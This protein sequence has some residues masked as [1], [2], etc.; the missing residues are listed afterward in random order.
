[1]PENPHITV[2]VPTFNEAEAITEL[3]ERIFS[4]PLSNLDV[5]IVDDNSPDNTGVIADNLSKRYPIRVIHRSSKEGLGKA[6]IHVFTELLSMTR[7][8]RPE[9]IIQ[10][11][12]DLSHNPADIPRFLEKIES[13]DVVLGSRYVT[14]GDIEYWSLFRRLVSRLGNAYAALV[15]GLPYKDLTS[16]YKC[17]RREVLEAIR[18]NTLSSTG[19]NFQIET[20]Y[21]AHKRGF[22][23]CEIPLVFT[24]RKFG[25]SKFHIG[26]IAESFIKVLM[27]RF[28]K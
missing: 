26:I 12:A 18:L 14:G 7:D 6:Y 17:F 4:L 1:M 19:Y 10:I 9:Y 24:E 23:I 5:V 27:L 11:D 13:C 20:T 22:R 8:L 15:L 2:V 16:G 28:M 3:V 25:S 21:E